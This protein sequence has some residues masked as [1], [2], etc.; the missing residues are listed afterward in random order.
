MLAWITALGP[1]FIGICVALIA[2][3][4]WRTAQAKVRLDLFDRRVKIYDEVR[5]VILG[6][7]GGTGFTGEVE[8]RYRIAIKD[9]AWLFDQDTRHFLDTTV[10]HKLVMLENWRNTWQANSDDT[11]AKDHSYEMVQESFKEL[12]S[13]FDELS[14]R[15]APFLRLHH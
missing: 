13:E 15:F 4:Q 2:Y 3:R 8:S 12:H 1:L 9:S 6:C 10:I 5:A 11:P 14:D 7:L